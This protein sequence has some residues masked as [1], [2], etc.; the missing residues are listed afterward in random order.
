MKLLGFRAK[1]RGTVNFLKKEIGEHL[2]FKT[3]T[4]VGKL[5]PQQTDAWL[6]FVYCTT[7]AQGNRWQHRQNFASC[8]DH[9]SW[10]PRD[11]A[12]RTGAASRIVRARAAPR[13][14][15][16]GHDGAGNIHLVTDGE[17]PREKRS[18]ASSRESP[19]RALRPLLPAS[20]G[21][22]STGVLRALRCMLPEAVITDL[23]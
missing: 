7:L 17:P 20:C 6:V 23:T 12:R 8:R 5:P 9:G 2:R 19:R 10:L 11:G 16:A 21:I 3:R 1:G 14:P 18:V 4:R 13:D 22:G 15:V